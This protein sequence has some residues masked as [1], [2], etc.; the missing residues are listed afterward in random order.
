MKK[1]LIFFLVNVVLL[2]LVSCEANREGTINYQFYTIPRSMLTKETIEWL[3][4]FNS[5]PRKSQIA[6][7]YFPPDLAEA[8]HDIYGDVP[9][10]R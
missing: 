4:N 3:E 10:Y 7:S 1:V 8:I 9:I 5:L 6:V 2:L